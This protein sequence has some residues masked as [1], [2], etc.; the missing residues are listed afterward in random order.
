[1]Y[2]ITPQH[3]LYC[4]VNMLWYSGEN[5]NRQSSMSKHFE[6][7]KEKLHL[8]NQKKRAP[9][10]GQNIHYWRKKTKCND[11]QQWY[12][13]TRGTK[14]GERDNAQCVTGNHVAA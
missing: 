6:Q 13:N 1:M 12:I 7:W 14:K 3:C 11:M 8:N 2:S 10:T 5:P 9:E 4:K